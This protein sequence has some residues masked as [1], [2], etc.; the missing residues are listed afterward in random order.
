MPL[1]AAAPAA[2]AAAA[3]AVTAAPAAV[4]DAPADMRSRAELLLAWLGAKRTLGTSAGC[5]G[6][7]SHVQYDLTKVK[8]V[9]DGTS[10][11]NA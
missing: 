5:T 6:S 2:S 10:H 4:E 3:G 11:C 7:C 1:P 8:V 9:T